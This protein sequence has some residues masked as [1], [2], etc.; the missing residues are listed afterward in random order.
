[1]T[2]CV[3]CSII[4]TNEPAH[5]LI[6]GNDKYLAF[7]DANPARPGHTL[8]VPKKHVETAFDLTEN[9]YAEWVV[10]GRKIGGR[11]KEV[12]GCKKIGFMIEGF[13]VPHAHLHLIPLNH[14]EEIFG[15]TPMTLEEMKQV[16]E[17]LRKGMENL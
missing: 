7:L 8:L 9:D 11:M 10:A 6:W 14:G 5:E 15:K 2:E 17:Q 3:F 4:A 1:M 16:G 12:L 13:A